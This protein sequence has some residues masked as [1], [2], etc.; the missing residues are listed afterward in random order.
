MF[1]NSNSASNKKRRR[2]HTPSIQLA[3]AN[4]TDQDGGKGSKKESLIMGKQSYVIL[5]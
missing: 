2:Q 4:E 5:R 3:F 1:I